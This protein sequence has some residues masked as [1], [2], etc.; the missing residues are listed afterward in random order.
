MAM[1]TKGKHHVEIFCFVEIA[2]FIF[3][4]SCFRAAQIAKISLLALMVTSLGNHL[5]L[6]ARCNYRPFVFMQSDA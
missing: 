6:H 1:L 2:L 4:D 5:V 3:S